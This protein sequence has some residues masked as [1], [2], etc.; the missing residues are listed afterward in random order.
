MWSKQKPLLKAEGPPQSLNQFKQ[1]KR[2][3]NEVNTVTNLKM[4]AMLSTRMMITKRQSVPEQ[5]Q[6]TS[7]FTALLR[8]VCLQ[9]KSRNKHQVPAS[10]T[11][12]NHLSSLNIGLVLSTRSSNFHPCFFLSSL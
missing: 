11:F 3:I 10:I 8:F 4:T 7:I 5:L 9:K 6:A 1:K 2:A 12:Q